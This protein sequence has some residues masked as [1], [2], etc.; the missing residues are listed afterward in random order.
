MPERVFR[1]SLKFALAWYVIV[2]VLCLAGVYAYRR[3]WP[4]QPEWVM[5][6]PVV[7]FF[8]PL[9][10]HLRRQA[11]KLVLRGD[12]LS[13]QSGLLGKN[14]RTMDLSKV[15]DVRVQ[16]SATQRMLGIGSLTIQT[17]GSGEGGSITMDSLD[18]PHAV[19]DLILDLSKREEIERRRAPGPGA[20]AQS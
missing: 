6:M 16:Q 19:A 3:F 7:L 2:I 20:G 17:A 10:M 4:D 9:R 15:Q 13:W 18:S 8:I 1:P 14:T 11:V 12:R 5:A